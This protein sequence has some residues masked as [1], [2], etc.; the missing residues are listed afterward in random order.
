MKH[1]LFFSAILICGYIQTGLSQAN[2]SVSFSKAGNNDYGDSSITT[3]EAI[4]ERDTLFH[5]SAVPTGYSPTAEE[6][7]YVSARE[8]EWK[9]NHQ[10][11]TASSTLTSQRSGTAQTTSI[12]VSKSVGQI[13][14]QEGNTPSGGKTY[15]IP[16]MTAPATASA[17]QIALVYN[18]QAGNGVAGYGWNISGYSVIAIT[19]KNHHYDNQATPVNLLNPNSYA[20]TLDGT[21]L[22]PNTGNIPEYQYE[23]A[24]GY[25]LVK[26]HL[27]NNAISHF[28]ALYPNGN[29]AIFGFPTNN[30]TQHLYPVTSITDMNGYRIDFEYFSSGNGYYLSRVRYGGKNT[31]SHVAEIKLEYTGR[32]D[33]TPVYLSDV[34][35]TADRLLTKIISYNNE[36]E[37]RTY[38]L[39]HTTADHVQRLTQL[40]CSVSGLSLNP[41]LFNYETYSP[42]YTGAITVSPYSG[43]LMQ[44]FS[45]R[46]QYIR[47]KFLK[48]EFND[49]LI[50]YPSFSTYTITGTLKRWIP[51]QY[52]YHHQYGSG[53]S[54]EQNLLIAR[55]LNSISSMET[56]KA[57]EGFQTINAIDVDGNGVDEVVKVNFDGTTDQH[58]R[59]KVTVYGY[60]DNQTL[61]SRSFTLNVDGVVRDHTLVSPISCSYYFGDFSGRGETQLL[62]VSHN[63]TFLGENRESKFY[64]V[65]LRTGNLIRK[66]T[67]FSHAP[68]EEVVALD[69][70]GD[71]KMELCRIGSST[72]V[73]ALDANNYFILLFNE[74]GISKDRTKL[75]ADLNGDGMTDILI[76]PPSFYT[77][78]E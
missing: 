36:Q 70:N 76:P 11:L 55:Q 57:G 48:D 26:K 8:R 60:N 42:G 66:S 73:Y 31:A 46:A 35:I 51:F 50:T 6:Q 19:G 52:L 33:Y 43:I 74:Y 32:T 27:R 40:G 65:N 15:S 77:R 3:V 68:N 44:Y 5:Y 29:R 72:A 71:G 30:I 23:T 37:L 75:Y 4:N 58:T 69:V 63:K 17:P 22:V 9:Q 53:Y 14:F 34:E 54:P 25:V 21:R 10:L 16:I 59:L 41:L 47:G 62:V 64:L 38:T 28:E 2:T 61:N 1:T 67:L 78:V 20:L 18:S 7:A 12:D 13:P 49:G 56:I 24:Q 39:T 45:E